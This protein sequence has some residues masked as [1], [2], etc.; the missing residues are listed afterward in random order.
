MRGDIVAYK[1]YKESIEKSSIETNT[2]AKGS[3]QEAP[4]QPPVSM[5]KGEVVTDEEEYVL[6]LV[7]NN[8]R[9]DYIRELAEGGQV[10]D[11]GLLSNKILC[12]MED[13]DYFV[14]DSQLDQRIVDIEIGLAQNTLNNLIRRR[15]ELNK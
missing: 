12:I 8:L 15:E 1:V 3:E 4:T 6:Q 13:P 11:T 7:L 9:G 2:N 14:S 10:V 5:I